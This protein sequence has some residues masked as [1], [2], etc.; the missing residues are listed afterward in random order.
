VEDRENVRVPRSN[1]L[2]AQ[3]LKEG[4]GF[5]PIEKEERVNKEEEDDPAVTR[6]E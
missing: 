6:I 2:R 3:G 4:I 5:V 1:R